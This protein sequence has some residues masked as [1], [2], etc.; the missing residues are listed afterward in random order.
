M[1]GRAVRRGEDA[2]SVSPTVERLPFAAGA[3]ARAVLDG[4]LPATWTAPRPRSVEA[5][6]QRLQ[7]SRHAP[8]GRDWGWT[9][10]EAFAASGPA[11]AR[12]ARVSEGQGVV[13]TTGQQPGLF[14]GPLYTL[15]KALS[16]LALADHLERTTGIP[17]APVFWAATDDTDFAEGA[18]IRLPGATGSATAQLTQPP[19]DGT[20]LAAAPVG[21]ATAALA[22]LRTACGGGAWA[23]L[24]RVA[25]EAY[26]APGA[27]V[28]GAYVA[29]LRH[30]L[31]PLGIAVLDAAHPDVRRAAHPW[32]RRALA[33]AEPLDLAVA[34]RTAALRERGLVPQVEPVADRALVFTIAD[35]RRVRASVAG[36]RATLHGLDDDALSPNVLLRP[37][38][39]RALLP[40]AAYVAGPGELAYFAQVGAVADLLDLPQPLAV[41]RASVRVLT[42][43]V[44][45][46]LARH[47]LAP[48]ELDAPHAA[49]ARLAHAGTPE[50]ALDALAELRATIRATASRLAAAGSALDPHVI[51]G[52]V[53]QLG[54]RVDRVERRLLAATKR[55]LDGELAQVAAAR[56]QLR[57]D[58]LPQERALS[59][60]PW[61]VRHGPPFLQALRAACDEAMRATTDG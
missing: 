1:R 10:R 24:A 33:D 40:T 49:E 37:V 54:H 19:P 15:V 42:P 29:L 60:V 45:A 13:I 58:G 52:A 31:Q 53:A 61:L 2:M 28:G 44:A 56:A 22:A 32:L 7:D 16:A 47:G 30:L 6:R 14:G 59:F 51:D 43:G 21:D 35:G 26:A 8:V 55:Q 20:M 41:P 27:T 50:A 57:P 39:E 17:V 36:A 12:L 4:T 46:V 11:A 18:S 48:S 25:H 38:V 5:W 34:A 23:D 9:L 3:T